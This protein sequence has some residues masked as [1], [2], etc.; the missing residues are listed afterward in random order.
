MSQN[1][2]SIVSNKNANSKIR[3]GFLGKLPKIN[4]SFLFVCL[5]DKHNRDG[6][7]LGDLKDL[8]LF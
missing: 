4:H 8:F 3:P 6:S 1:S 5:F 7:E 2:L